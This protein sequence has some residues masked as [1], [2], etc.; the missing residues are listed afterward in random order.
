VRVFVAGHRGMVGSAVTRKLSED[1]IVVTAERKELDLRNR[2][3]VSNFL[4]KESIDSVVLAAAKVGGIFAN[5]NNQTDF[6][7]E[8]LE[9]QNSVLLAAR[10]SDV[11]NFI[12]LGS[13]CMYPRDA[14]QPMCESQLLHGAPE[15]TNAGY[16]IAKNAGTFLCSEIGKSSGRNF[17]TL[18]PCNLYGQGDNFDLLSSHVPAALL[19]KAHE[20]KV[21][22]SQS[23]TVWGSGKPLREFMFVEDLAEACA[24]FLAQ[25]LPGEVVNI[26]SGEEV[27]I[28]EFAEI[29]CKVVG[30]EGEII[31]DDSKPDGMPRKIMNSSKAN[32]YG[33]TKNFSLLEGLKVT[34]E[35][36]KAT[37]D[38]RGMR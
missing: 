3:D 34:Y 30:F 36:F 2:A 15:P 29:V 14:N 13:S 37:P 31:Y 16:S 18:V 6:L 8:N 20:A 22:N 17:L 32:Q 25:N 38:V 19:R 26:G 1:H 27:S 9:I 21:K 5:S 11:K 4:R 23:I 7:V 10:D 35:W 28:K 12:F 24:F 33:W